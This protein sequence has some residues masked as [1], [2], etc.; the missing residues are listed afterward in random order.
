MPLAGEFQEA[1]LRKELRDSM[2][3]QHIHNAIIA[4]VCHRRIPGHF[5]QAVIKDSLSQAINLADNDNLL[6][7]KDIVSFFYNHT[8]SPCNGSPKAMKDWLMND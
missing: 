4:Y 8:P 1:S 3:P 7:L 6:H 5:L 2:V